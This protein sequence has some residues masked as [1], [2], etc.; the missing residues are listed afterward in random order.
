MHKKQ[1]FELEEKIR[2]LHCCYHCG[3]ALSR[4]FQVWTLAR[5]SRY[6]PMP[7]RRSAVRKLHF[8]ESALAEL[9]GVALVT[10][11]CLINIGESPGYF[12]FRRMGTGGNGFQKPG[13]V[14]AILYTDEVES[15]K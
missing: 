7:V 10:R 4:K 3:Q 14:Y 1:K 8:S 5:L 9:C 11:S 15:V 6:L 2:I 12:P 13:T